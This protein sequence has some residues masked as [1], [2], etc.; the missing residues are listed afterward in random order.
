MS[1]SHVRKTTWLNNAKQFPERTFMI[2]GLLHTGLG[3]FLLVLSIV[4]IT[5]DLKAMK[6]DCDYF[7]E[8]TRYRLGFE[9]DWQCWRRKDYFP[10]VLAFDLTCLVFSGLYV[11][12]VFLSPCISRTRERCCCGLTECF[13]VSILF[14]TL[15]FVPILLGICGF[16]PLKGEESDKQVNVSSVCMALSFAVLAI[17]I[18]AGTYSSFCTG[19]KTRVIYVQQLGKPI[20]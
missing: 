7:F 17:S 11:F 12:V 20:Y 19:K 14:G 6:Q 4:E 2:L 16:G 10:Q 1:R 3:V 9:S 18:V 15:T 13:M 8:M 5:L